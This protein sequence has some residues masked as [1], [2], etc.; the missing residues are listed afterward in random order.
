VH[1]VAVGGDGTVFFATDHE[2]AALGAA[3]KR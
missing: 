3:V 1:A 2:I